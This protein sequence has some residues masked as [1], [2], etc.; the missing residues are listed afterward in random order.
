MLFETTANTPAPSATKTHSAAPAAASR[1]N[2]AGLREVNLGGPGAAG[3]AGPVL[4]FGTA[5]NFI[6]PLRMP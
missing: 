1:K 4:G 3:G 2:A 5:G 6:Q